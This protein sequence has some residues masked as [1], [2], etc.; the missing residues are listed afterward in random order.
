MNN[1]V[2][3]FI[4]VLAAAL[5]A[6]I[7]YKVIFDSRGGRGSDARNPSTGELSDRDKA[8]MA[9]ELKTLLLERRFQS[10]SPANPPT[11]GSYFDIGEPRVVDVVTEGAS[12]RV[13]LEVA[14]TA[15]GPVGR[16]SVLAESCYGS[17]QNGFTPGM[18]A[19]A[20]YQIRIERW[21]AGWQ[22]VR[23]VDLSTMTYPVLTAIQ[24]TPIQAADERWLAGQW[25]TTSGDHCATWIR[26]NADHTFSDNVANSGTWSLSGNGRREGFPVYMLTMNSVATGTHTGEVMHNGVLM[27]MGS[28]AG[29]VFWQ[30]VTC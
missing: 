22:F 30:R 12:G 26:F 17:P 16:D 4:I 3:T 11:C 18:T 8:S 27:I 25:A 28:G 7:L 23:P 21:Q 29:S 19:P 2:R 6:L 14:I 13:R 9:S 15:R 20:T 5:A 24:G 10:L 1:S